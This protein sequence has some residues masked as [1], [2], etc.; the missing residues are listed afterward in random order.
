ME[1]RA[2]RQIGQ[3]DAKMSFNS[4]PGR[5][6]PA[7]IPTVIALCIAWV[8]DIAFAV[9]MAVGMGRSTALFD[10]FALALAMSMAFLAYLIYFTRQYIIDHTNRYFFEI[11]DY[12]VRFN[13][14]SDNARRRRAAQM[15]FAE[16][17]FV[18]HFTPR[19]N[20]SLVFHGKK[21]RS[22]D[23]PIWS[24]MDDA[25][26]ILAFLKEHGVPVLKI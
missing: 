20:A 22:L 11:T 1:G 18:E 9:S 23:V 16:M 5:R 6:R 17:S 19:D 21:G 2:N 26:E 14:D 4:R 10:E 7:F 24:M 15:A 25:S 3:R 8:I 13:V 12:G